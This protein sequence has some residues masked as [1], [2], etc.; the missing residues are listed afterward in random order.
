MG[1][2]QLIKCLLMSYLIFLVKVEVRGFEP[3]IS[4]KIIHFN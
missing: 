4:K 2:L 1:S 3:P